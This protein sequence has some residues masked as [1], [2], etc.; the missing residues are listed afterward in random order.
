VPPSAYAG[1]VDIKITYRKDADHPQYGGRGG[2]SWAVE[3]TGVEGYDGD[4]AVQAILDAG[5]MMKV[6]AYGNAQLIVSGLKGWGDAE[7]SSGEAVNP[8]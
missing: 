6:A 5:A 8:A 3:A 2:E 1:I 7:P 4:K